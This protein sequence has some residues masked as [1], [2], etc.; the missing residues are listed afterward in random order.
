MTRRPRSWLIEAVVVLA[1]VL[2]YWWRAATRVDSSVLGRGQITEVPAQTNPASWQTHASTPKSE[3]PSGTRGAARNHLLHRLNN[4]GLTAGQLAKQPDAILLENAL[5]S[6]KKPV[7][8]AVPDHLRS[9]SDPQTYIAQSRSALDR[10]F[11]EMLKQAGATIV[12]YIPNNAYLIRGSAEV[13]RRVETDEQTRSVLPYEPYY[14]L[15][16]SLLDL[17]VEYQPLPENAALN[18]L[19]FSDAQDATLRA[20]KE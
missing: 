1:V 6:T 18:V 12:S 13:A 10:K 7:Q 3:P 20:L 19:L 11:R 5:W 15:K 16:G 14:K 8:A 2:F 17:A 4:T 9:K